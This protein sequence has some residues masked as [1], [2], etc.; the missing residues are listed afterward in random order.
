MTEATVSFTGNLTDDPQVRYTDSGIARATVRVAVSGR[1]GQEA[2][3][4][5]VIV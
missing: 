3:L 4:F 2:S 1:R 5:T